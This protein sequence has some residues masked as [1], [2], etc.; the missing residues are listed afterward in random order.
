[1]ARYIQ[2]SPSLLSDLISTLSVCSLYQLLYLELV[3]EDRQQMM[4][5]VAIFP[6]IIQSCVPLVVLPAVT[7]KVAIISCK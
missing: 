7:M 1:M 3:V 5:M 4:V 6:W 2:G